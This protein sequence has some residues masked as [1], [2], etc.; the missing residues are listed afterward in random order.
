MRGRTFDGGITYLNLETLDIQTGFNDELIG[1][2]STHAG[3]TFIKS[4]RGD[5]SIAINT[6]DG[7]L[8]IETGE[9]GDQIYT[10][11]TTSLQR[12]N[13]TQQISASSMAYSTVDQL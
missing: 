4:G 11:S 9:G 1:V 7:H 6:T 3:T 5:D 12:D 8:F 13:Q 10:S 2:E